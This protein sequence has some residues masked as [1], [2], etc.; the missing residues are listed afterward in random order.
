M[1]EDRVAAMTRHTW[2]QFTPARR[3]SEGTGVERDLPPR[4]RF[5]LVWAALVAT[6]CGCEHGALG[7]GGKARP[8]VSIKLDA[9]EGETAGVEE[10]VQ[11]AGYGTV[12]GRVILDGTA[13]SRPKSLPANL[14]DPTVCQAPLIPDERL[15]VGEGGGIKNVFVFLDRKPKGTKAGTP[16]PA[17]ATF[18]QKSCTFIPHALIL[19]AGQ[20][21]QLLNSDPIAHNINATP[22]NGQ[23]LNS[24][25]RPSDTVGS[26]YTY[27]AGERSPVRVKCD[28]HGW[29][30]AWHLPLDHPYGA[31]TN[32]KG[33]FT[34]GDL[35]AGEHRFVV[36]HEGNK[37]M[38]YPVTIQVDQTTPVEIKVNSSTF[39]QAAPIGPVKTVVL[40]AIGN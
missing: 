3:A 38:D 40:S 8:S 12:T 32:E 4:L 19:R 36:Y 5:G 33:E 18:D 23:A 27:A 28:I 25:L 30:V 37:L 9:P 21:F 17:A 24:L 34:I 16:A 13:P 11:V 7:G 35:P 2:R 10:T 15:I 6:L 1:N 31:V 29:M 39:A 14:S 20:P 26:P 22:R